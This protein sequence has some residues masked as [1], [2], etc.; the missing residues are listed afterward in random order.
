MPAF[1]YSESPTPDAAVHF[2]FILGTLDKADRVLTLYTPARPEWGVTEAA[3][4]L[5]E[6]PSSTHLLMS[7]LAQ[8]GVLHRTVAGRHRLGFPL[9]TL[10]QIL[11]A[12]TPWRETA[13]LHT[14][15]LSCAIGETIA[16]LSLLAPPARFRARQVGLIQA[17]QDAAR[18]ASLAIG[19]VP[20]LAGPGQLV[21]A[22]VAGQDTLRA[23]TPR[24]HH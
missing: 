10:G 18:R 17:T 15:A 1:H 2:V 4:T 12:N 19:H 23:S 24:R 6:P 7:S 20:E 9:L 13:A 3:R 14:H 5:G 16:A 11:L 21:W 8:M 22:S